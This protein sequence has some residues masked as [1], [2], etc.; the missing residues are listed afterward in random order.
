MARKAAHMTLDLIEEKPVDE[1]Y[2]V[3]PAHLAVRS[4]TAKIR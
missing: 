2:V 1:P 4:S 3:A